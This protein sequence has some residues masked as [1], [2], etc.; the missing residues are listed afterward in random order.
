MRH[1]SISIE[2]LIRTGLAKDLITFP[3]SVFLTKRQLG[4]RLVISI[5]KNENGYSV[6]RWNIYECDPSQALPPMEEH[7]VKD[8]FNDPQVILPDTVM[9]NFQHKSIPSEENSVK[10]PM[11][12][13]KYQNYFDKYLQNFDLHNI[14]KERWL[15]N[16]FLSIYHPQIII[17]GMSIKRSIGF[18]GSY[19][20]KE[21]MQN[22]KDIIELHFSKT[23]K[24]WNIW[25]RHMLEFEG[26]PGEFCFCSIYPT[27]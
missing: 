22:Q 20:E 12:S 21:I 5:D 26:M 1:H 9:L 24:F 7:L 27:V 19:A 14:A 8:L 15:W 3:C 17:L 18:L 13:I 4:N 25:K 16:S 6:K 10:H 11:P 23:W 2:Y